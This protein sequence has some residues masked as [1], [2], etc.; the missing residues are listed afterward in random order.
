MDL[1][2]CVRWTWGQAEL[3]SLKNMG[4]S[5]PWHTNAHTTGHHWLK[6]RKVF[7]GLFFLL[8]NGAERAPNRKL[9][10]KR[11]LIYELG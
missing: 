1:A 9:T 7:H 4:N 5:L 10:I 8:S 11:S 2:G 3:C 6:V